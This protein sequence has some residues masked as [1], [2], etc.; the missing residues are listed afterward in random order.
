MQDNITP[1]WTTSQLLGLAPD[2]FLLKNGR[3]RVHS[4]LWHTFGRHQDLLWGVYNRKETSLPPYHISVRLS[5]LQT[6]CNCGSQKTPCQLTLGLL[7]RYNL[8]PQQFPTKTPP[9]WLI[10]WADALPKPTDPHPTPSNK[11]E[12]DQF[13]QIQAGMAEFAL[14]LKDIIHNGLGELPPKAKKTFDPMIHRLYDTHATEIAHELKL[15][16]TR[17]LPN[18]KKAAPN[19]AETLL[20]TFGRYYLLTQ[21]WQNIGTFTAAEQNDLRAAIGLTHYP[22]THPD[23]KPM[24]G[25]WLVLGSRFEVIGRQRTRRVWLQ[26]INNGRLALLTDPLYSN[27]PSDQHYATSSLI[28]GTAY[29]HPATTRLNANLHIEKITP[30]HTLN[31]PQTATDSIQQAQHLFRTTQLTNPWLKRL[32]Q[33]YHNIYL[34]YR[35]QTW[36]LVDNQGYALPLKS[37]ARQDWT[38]LSHNGGRPLTLFG[39]LYTDQFEPLS[40][41]D[42]LSNRWLDLSV[43]GAKR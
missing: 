40:L 3:D 17:L 32:P 5:D 42:P 37:G 1:N 31:K 13:P 43:W 38:I 24:A 27:R 7:L 29:F 8:E 4:P 36:W 23:V 11:S 19:W 14:W 22:L 26:E 21:A 16:H 35:E 10:S 6:H 41:Y 20:Q 30:Q 9:D 28:Q 39:E 25:Q 15:L 34:R 12:T 18:K 2:Q 33:Q